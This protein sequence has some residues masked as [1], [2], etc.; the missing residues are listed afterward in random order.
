MRPWFLFLLLL[1][2]ALPLALRRS[3]T[4]MTPGQRLVCTT[5]RA[6]ILTLLVLALVGVTWK[7]KSD[8]LSVLFVVDDSGSL[9]AEARE[10]ALS[11]IREAVGNVRPN[12][13]VGVIGFSVAPD[14][15]QAP[16]S[17]LASESEWPE[18]NLRSGTDVAEALRF[19]SAVFPVETAKRIVLLSDGNDTGHGALET[20]QTLV[21]QGISVDTV[22]LTNP[23][24][25]EVL[26]ETVE[27]PGQLK[28]G[29]PFDI[30]ARVRSSVESRAQ[31]KLYRNQF[32][33]SE[34]AVDLHRGA[35]DVVFANI[36]PE[37]SFAAYEVE[38]VPSDDTILE[39]NRAMAT[40]SV[41]GEP[42]V[43]LVDSDEQKL[44]PLTGALR[45]ENIHTELRGLAGLPTSMEDLQQFDLFVLSD[46]SALG[47]T[48]EQMNLYQ[49]WVRDFGGGFLM[50]G[51]ENSFGVGGYFR[52]AIEQ[53]LP[54]RMEHDDRQ[55][56]PSVALL[57]VLDRSGSMSAHVQG[58][59]KM[60]L[61]N[62]GAVFAL[63]VLQPKDLFGLLAVD[64]KVHAIVPMGRVSDRGSL[65]QKILS[66]TPGGGGI[67]IYT[68]LVE[69]FRELRDANAKIKHVILFS[70]AKD[71]EEKNAGDMGD[72][73]RVG[74]SSLDLVT[75]MLA[76]RITTSVVALGYEQDKDTAFL[77]QLAERGNG[78]FY[79]TNDA[80]TLPKIFSTETMKVAQSSLVEEPFLPVPMA[81]GS[82]T[83]GIDWSQV[84]LLLGYNT[85][86][87]KP[88]A[89]VL[90]ATE[91][92][93]PLYA[94]WRYGLGQT[95]AFTSDAKA[96]W[97]S[98]WLGWSGYG[99]FWA[100]TVRSLMRRSE[101]SGFQ[102]S[103]TEVGD[104]IRLRI[105]VVTPEGNFRNEL[106]ITVTARE[107]E[108]GKS[109]TQ[110][111][112]QV[113]PGAYE[114]WFDLPPQGTTLF[115]VSSRDLPEGDYVFGHTRSYPKEYLATDTD[116]DYLR[117]LAKAGNGR[118]EPS[119]EEIFDRPQKSSMRR[120]DLTRYFLIAA[121]ILFPFDIWLRRRVW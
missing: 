98:E 49:R 7:A 75:A 1:P 48:R 25:P 29:Q 88:T 94:T 22:P 41:R 42:K 21:E 46:V 66:I 99:K 93:E 61:A 83:A 16:G 76:N 20:A 15:W 112:L 87:P 26:L 118:Y 62:Q 74:G 43:L 47:L 57:V 106:P 54:V 103:T 77:K 4:E 44:Q 95:A 40:V 50:L 45:T 114:V 8:N 72:G 84:P 73:T 9:S 80:T 5:V 24:R 60:A 97:G 89:D 81:N 10:Q 13:R 35:Q 14:L 6:I 59:T 110:S 100:Q 33:V 108:T 121:L 69:S 30:V 52:T 36:E 117:T 107:D 2:A 67:Y 12:D 119:A 58:Q 70:D 19:A 120:A 55:D 71:A 65:E 115:S 86:K 28:T 51:G 113:G 17:K 111:A 34:Q 102:V 3:L 82:A 104:R 64:S 23:K 78:R 92:G 11:Y 79:L 37:G 85:T 116:R 96:R 101:N 105:D 31:V 90:L 56:T 18:S 39:N 38:V 32:L 27:L 63:E 68:S 91:R 109:V 53:M